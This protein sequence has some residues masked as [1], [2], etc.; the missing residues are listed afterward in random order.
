MAARAHQ[1]IMARQQLGL[2]HRKVGDDLLT[3]GESCGKH[4]VYRLMGQEQTLLKVTLKRQNPHH[5]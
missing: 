1:K 2:W 4:H 3:L 5:Y